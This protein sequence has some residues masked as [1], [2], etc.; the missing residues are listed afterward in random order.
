MDVAIA[1]SRN[2]PKTKGG[3]ERE[4]L[5]SELNFIVS[6]FVPD[7]LERFKGSRNE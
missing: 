3:V 2:T 4:L 6:L 7:D 1:E 5:S